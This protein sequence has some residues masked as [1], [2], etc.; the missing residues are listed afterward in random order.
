MLNAATSV[1]IDPLTMLALPGSVAA[2]TDAGPA[3]ALA[4]EAATGAAPPEDMGAPG[5]LQAVVDTAVPPPVAAQPAATLHGSSKPK[6]E[7]AQQ[8]AAAQIETPEVSTATAPDPALATPELRTDE[9]AAETE[10]DDEPVADLLAWVASLPLPPPAQAAAPAQ[11]RAA[12]AAARPEASNVATMPAVR[13]AAVE[14]AARKDSALPAPAAPMSA[15]A[16]ALRKADATSP[17]GPLPTVAQGDPP[18]VDGGGW[19]QALVAQREAGHAPVRSSTDLAL[20]LPALAGHAAS[21]SAR[22]PD[23]GTS[24]QA[25]VHAELGSKEFAPALGSQLSVLVR[26]GVEH[27]Q[28]KLNPAD[29]GPIEVRISIDGSQAQVDF[30]AAHA[31]TRQ[32]LQDAVPV[33]ASALRDNGLTLAGGGVFEQPRESRGDTPTHPGHAAR[34]AQERSTDE[35]LPTGMAP[36]LP[37]ARGVLDLYA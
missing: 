9:S 7:L 10:A 27:A 17:R 32:A 24:V 33:L 19:L 5:L 36:R 31:H 29:M 6:S 13:S 18:R 22:A 11:T 34:A 2:E 26:N 35:A 3:F 12:P 23:P 37:H 30:S 21:P 20:P 4:L 8:L 16:A 14:T 15:Q 28:L 1:S 25:E